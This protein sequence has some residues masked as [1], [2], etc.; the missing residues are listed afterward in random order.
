MRHYWILDGQRVVPCSESVWKDF[1]R[2][3]LNFLLAKTYI[4]PGFLIQT[5]FV[6][7]QLPGHHP[8]FFKTTVYTD[9]GQQERFTRTH[10]EAVLMHQMECQRIASIVARNNWHLIPSD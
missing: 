1:R 8:V 2:D 9:L 4:E 7:C 10:E 5:Q 3:A 6:G